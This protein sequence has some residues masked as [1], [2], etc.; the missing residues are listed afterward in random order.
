MLIQCGPDF[1]PSERDALA[2]FLTLRPTDLQFAIEFR[3]LA[4]ITR[5]WLLSQGRTVYE[6]ANNHFAGHSPATV[7]M[8][9]QRLGLPTVAPQEIGEQGTLF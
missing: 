8:L 1:A 3:Q 2:A 4:W 5:E 9:L 6:F 7:R